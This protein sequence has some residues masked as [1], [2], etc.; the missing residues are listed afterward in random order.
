MSLK[1]KGKLSDAIDKAQYIG[2]R[3]GTLWP[4]FLN[5]RQTIKQKFNKTKVK[6][7]TNYST[8]TYIINFDIGNTAQNGC[9]KL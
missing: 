1:E 3:N 7:I 8:N 5:L 9:L 6:F 4:I 2:N